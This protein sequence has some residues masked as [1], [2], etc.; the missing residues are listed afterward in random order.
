M[1]GS[2]CGCLL[3]FLALIFSTVILEP[4][5]LPAQSDQAASS[6]EMAVRPLPKAPL[7]AAVQLWPGVLEPLPPVLPRPLPVL[8]GTIGFPQLARAAG[9]IFLGTVTAI[10]GRPTSSPAIATVAITFHVENA[11]RGTVPSDDFTVRQWMGLWS[12]GQRYRVGERL[13]LFLYPPSKLGL[14]SC[15]G[16]TLG[17]FRV[18]PAGRVLLS[19]QQFS[20]FQRD[21]VLGGRSHLLV[22]DFAWAVRQASEEE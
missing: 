6:R 9:T 12:N 21:P 17:R 13:M 1:S 8:P 14:T 18:D 4:A 16:G 15:V 3:V 10:E 20:A 11:I 22:R 7:S 5:W 2:R 19:P